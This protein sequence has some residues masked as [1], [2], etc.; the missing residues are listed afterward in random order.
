MWTLQL[1]ADRP[2]RVD[3]MTGL[4]HAQVDDLV[5]QLQTRG[6]WAIHRH[7]ALDPHHC[8]VAVLL[9]LRHN[10]S[11][12][13]LAALFGCSQ[14]T[15]SRAITLLIPMITELLTPLADRV[16]DRELRSTVRVDGFLAPIGDRRANTYTAGM[17]SGKRH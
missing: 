9:Y 13:L 16:A 3:V 17:Y 5:R 1:S 6:L 8:V 11:Q 7:R 4:T 2:P 12:H 10:L 15:V 14:P